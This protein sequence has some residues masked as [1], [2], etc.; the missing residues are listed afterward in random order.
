MP[1][2][3]VSVSYD[4]KNYETYEVEI[5]RADYETEDAYQEALQEFDDSP[6]DFCD[7]TNRTKKEEGDVRNSSWHEDVEEINPLDQI[8][9]ALKD[10]AVP[11]PEFIKEIDDSPY[12]ELG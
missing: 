5:L 8:V 11:V 7:I 10:D 9:D 4:I 2:Y 3:R 12:L 6:Y 1:K